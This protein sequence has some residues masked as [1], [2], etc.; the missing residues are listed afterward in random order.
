[1]KTGPVLRRRRLVA[2]VAGAVLGLAGCA[3]ILGPRTFRVEQDEL[4]SRLAARFPLQRNLL[5]LYEVR[6][7]DPQLQLLPQADR[8]AL[9]LQLQFTDQRS[10]RRVSASIALEFGLRY[11]AAATALRLVEPRVQRI[12]RVPDGTE[13]AAVNERVLRAALPLAEGWLD[14]QAIYRIPPQR[15]ERLRAAGY[16][17]GGLKIVPGAV[18]ITLLPLS[19]SAPAASAP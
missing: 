4:A 8:V 16:R 2:A 1:M 9:G 14:G 13:P 12:E 3:E 11:D 7:S 5:D 19:A 17:P 15:L 18:E 6:L 10:G